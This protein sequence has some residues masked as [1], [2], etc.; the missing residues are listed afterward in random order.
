MKKLN[1]A[2]LWHMHQP[3]YKDSL[4]NRYYLPWVRLHALKGYYDMPALLSNFPGVKMNFNLTPSLLMQ[5]EDYV[6]DSLI[7]DD[8]L[9]LSRTKADDLSTQDKYFILGHFFMNNWERIIK[10]HPRYGE[11]LRKRGL[12]YDVHDAK[13]VIDQFTKQDFLDLQVLFNLYW[14]GYMF[15]KKYS[16]IARLKKKE[17]NYTESDKHEILNLQFVALAEI[18]PL[19]KSMQESGHIEVSTSPLYHPIL[20]LLHDDFHEH[21][22]SWQNDASYH[23]DQA[24]SCYSKTFGTLPKGMWPSEGSVSRS[25]LPHFTRNNVKWI[26]SDEDILF[27]SLGTQNRMQSLYQ[28]YSLTVEGKKVAIIFRDKHLSD[29]IGFSYANSAPDQAAKDFMRHLQS[30]RHAVSGFPGEHLVSVILDGENAWEYYYDG[31]E[32]FLSSLYAMLQDDEAFNTVRISDFLS[33]ETSFNELHSLHAG[34]WINHNFDIWIGHQEDKTAWNLLERTRTFLHN[35]RC[36]Q[37]LAKR[38][39]KEIYIAQGSDWF[40]WYGDEFASATDAVFDFLFRMHLKNVYTLLGAKVPLDLNEPIKSSLKMTLVHEPRAFIEPSIDGH[41][42]TFYEWENAGMYVFNDAMSAM[43]TSLRTFNTLYFGFNVSSL[44]FRLDLNDSIE[45]V[46]ALSADCAIEIVMRGSLFRLV[47][48]IQKEPS[49][50][51]SECHDGVVTVISD[52]SGEIAFESIFEVR[53]SFSSLGLSPQ[54]SLSFSICVIENNIVS[55]KWPQYDGI[56]L[57]VPTSDFENS[58]WSV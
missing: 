58:M 14:F 27:Q 6:N 13:T 20:P 57:I 25:I 39:W 34:S 31:G 11:L 9:T 56:R 53:I 42:T 10:P 44:F 5:I 45:N 3:L 16:D 35:A 37:D 19:Y 2:F 8:F 15:E 23:V 50:V 48:A 24:L 26:A 47:F 28:P 43:Q 17:R 36:D 49:L 30:I 21:G 29:L 22:Y 18:I 38:A 51:L 32:S 1:I 4:A 41:V 12:T 55:E 7:Q 54:D 46:S 52:F 33:H 40:W